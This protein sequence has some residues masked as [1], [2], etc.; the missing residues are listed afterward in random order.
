MAVRTP[1]KPDRTRDAGG[2]YHCYKCPHELAVAGV[3]EKCCRSC[4]V[5]LVKKLFAAELAVLRQQLS[6]IERR[7]F[8]C[9]CDDIGPPLFIAV[10]GGD[11]SLALLHVANELLERRKSARRMQRNEKKTADKN[12]LKNNCDL[13]QKQDADFKCCVAL[14]VDL[15][16]LFIPPGS[17]TR[18]TASAPFWPLGASG[19]P[20]RG[21]KQCRNV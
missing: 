17:L 16:R 18:V 19:G 7:K 8:F 4:L 13:V 6:M 10:S 11:A 9:G 5:Q 21:V 14:H 15:Q 2:R 1:G 12:N 20:P 3:R